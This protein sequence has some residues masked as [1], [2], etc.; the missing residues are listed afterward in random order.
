MPVTSEV[1]DGVI[2]LHMVG[3]YSTAELRD[4]FLDAIDKAGPSGAIGMSFDVSES[5]SLAQRSVEEVTSM[6]YFIASRA[7]RF[8]RRVALI[9]ANDFSF[10]MMRL[11]SATLDQQGVANR[12]FRSEDEGRAWL[13]QP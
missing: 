2:A 12:V 3:V 8:G 4:A 9:G 5:D 11:G 7:D 6:G 1:K 13:L 10:G